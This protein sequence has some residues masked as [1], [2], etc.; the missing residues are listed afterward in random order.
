MPKGAQGSGVM[1][2]GRG[3]GLLTR[4]ASRSSSPTTKVPN[5]CLE[6]VDVF[7]P[8]RR[9]RRVDGAVVW[10]EECRRQGRS[11]TTPRQHQLLPRKSSQTTKESATKPA[12]RPLRLPDL[13][14]ELGGLPLEELRKLDRSRAAKPST[15]V[16]LYYHGGG[17]TTEQTGGA[18]RLEPS[19]GPTSGACDSKYL[20][21]PPTPK[22][23]R[24]P[25]PD[26]EPLDDAPFC[27]CCA[28]TGIRNFCTN[29]GSILIR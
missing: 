16:I 2:E 25:T 12:A 17:M 10:I 9:Q 21:P 29:C 1:V 26:L 15:P 28:E 11:N 3:E 6:S 5:G 7:A 27:D 8:P 19:Y 24:L 18:A 14:V 22:I 23:G 20:S 13:R 4:P